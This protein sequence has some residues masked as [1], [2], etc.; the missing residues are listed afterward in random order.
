MPDNDGLQITVNTQATTVTVADRSVLL[1]VPATPNTITIADQ[2]NAITSKVFGTSI[3]NGIDEIPPSILRSITIPFTGVIT[4]W[5]A[6]GDDP[7]GSIVIDVFRASF[8]VFNPPLTY[9]TSICGGGNKPNLTSQS[10]SSD[11][12]LTGWNTTVNS[13]DII[14]FLVDSV[15]DHTAVSLVIKCYVIGE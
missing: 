4:G 9:G 2:P 15:T 13:G 10:K 14:T 8:N 12:V 6:T 7:T 11:T 3:G 5:Y 1:S